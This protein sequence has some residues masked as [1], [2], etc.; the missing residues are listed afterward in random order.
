[1]RFIRV[2]VYKRNDINAKV[3]LCNGGEGLWYCIFNGLLYWDSS[4]RAIHV[5]IIFL[6]LA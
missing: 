4:T 5:F 2:S 6:I 1:M 3:P